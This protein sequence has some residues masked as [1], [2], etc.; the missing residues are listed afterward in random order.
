MDSRW[1]RG[2]KT[3]EEKKTIEYQLLHCD[4]LKVQLEKILDSELQTLEKLE[5]SD[6]SFDNPNWAAKQANILGQKKQIILLKKLFF[7]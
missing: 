3:D 2:L 6:A 5:L 1:K 4:V 7:S